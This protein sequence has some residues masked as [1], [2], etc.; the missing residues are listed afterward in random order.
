M[1]LWAPGSATASSRCGHSALNSASAHAAGGVPVAGNCVHAG[2]QL[3]ARGDA[4]VWVFTSP[5]APNRVL[6]DMPSAVRTE[7]TIGT[8]PNLRIGTAHATSAGR[9]GWTRQRNLSERSDIFPSKCPAQTP[10]DESCK[11]QRRCQL[12]GTGEAAQP[13]DRLFARDY[14]RKPPSPAEMCSA[15][16]HATAT[17]PVTVAAC[18]WAGKDPG[19]TRGAEI[20]CAKD[21][22]DEA[23]LTAR[24]SGARLPTRGM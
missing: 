12:P 24:S 20:L 10:F 19:R 22:V 16:P 2:R 8:K 3:E 17:Y 9:R 1:T 23:E 11:S 6:T 13:E 5:R 14:A 18:P 15:T 7:R 4:E 21:D